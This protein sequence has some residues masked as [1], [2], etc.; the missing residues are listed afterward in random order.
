MCTYLIFLVWCIQTKLEWEAD[1][2][3]VFYSCQ[4]NWGTMPHFLL[5]N[6]RK[7]KAKRLR[8]RA[9]SMGLHLELWGGPQ[10]L[11]QV[12]DLRTVA[13]QT[14]VNTAAFVTEQN[15]TI[16]RGPTRIWEGE[17]KALWVTKYCTTRLQ[18]PL[19][20][21]ILTLFSSHAS[22]C[23]I[24]ALTKLWAIHLHLYIWL[25]CTNGQMCL[26]PLKHNMLF[27]SFAHNTVSLEFKCCYSQ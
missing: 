11:G 3:A 8:I 6:H 13:A 21:Q 10:S 16:D 15:S 1:K 17:R 22:L 25:F 4:R 2:T 27:R 23:H 24:M 19:K 18:I 5:M 12:P 7:C 20:R 14:S 9:C 26:F